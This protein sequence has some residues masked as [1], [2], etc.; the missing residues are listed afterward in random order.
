MGDWKGVLLGVIDNPEAKIEL[1]NLATDI[2][3]NYNVADEY[4]EIV[5]QITKIMHMTHTP[6]PIFHFGWMDEK[7][8]VSGVNSSKH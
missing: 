7:H 5:S 1:Y 6:S 8:D 4:P 3:E 2:H